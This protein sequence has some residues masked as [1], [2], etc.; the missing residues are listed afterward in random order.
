[1]RFFALRGEIMNKRDIKWYIWGGLL[2]LFGLYS[3]I[4]AVVLIAVGLVLLPPVAKVLKRVEL[5]QSR[6]YALI[7]L[8]IILFA[9]RLGAPEVIE[10]AGAEIEAAAEAAKEA[11][12]VGK[13]PAV[14]E[15]VAKTPPVVKEAEEPE[16]KPVIVEAT[17][18]GVT[19][20]LHRL[21]A[22]KV[23]SNWGKVD[24]VDITIENND[25]DKEDLENP[26][27]EFFV[28]DRIGYTPDKNKVL[29]EVEVADEVKFGEVFT[30]K[31]SA[32]ANYEKSLAK[33]LLVRVDLTQG[34]E[35]DRKHVVSV[36]YEVVFE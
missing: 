9:F 15:T 33:R 19:L 1:M 7:T 28:Y 29:D 34:K 36:Q 13:A 26:R 5:S 10:E 35:W 25:P 11:A 31:I 3:D 30:G 32:D 23:G 8:A 2:I 16:D 12:D 6:K 22:V 27:L 17:T 24:E 18:K 21:N 4:V 14:E 20:T